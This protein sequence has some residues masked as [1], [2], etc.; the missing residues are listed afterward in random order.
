[1]L[2][3]VAVTLAVY[4]L[5]PYISS[6]YLQMLVLSGINV[7]LANSLNLISGITGQLSLGHAGF[8]AIGAYASAYYSLQFPGT[9]HFILSLLIGGTFAGLSGLLLGLP[10]LRLKGD[11]LAI[12]TLGFSEM[13]RVVFLNMEIVGGARGL[14]QIP[15]HTNIVWVAFIVSFTLLF[16]HRYMGSYA[17][18]AFLAIRENEMA[19]QTC[20]IHTTKYKVMSFS[21]GAFFA[22]TAGALFAHHLTYISPSI[23]TFTKSFEILTMV[24]LGGLGSLSGATISAVLL[25]FLPEVLRPLQ[26]ITHIDLRMVIYSLLLIILM[27]TRP[28]GMMGKKEIWQLFP[29]I[30]MKRKK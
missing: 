12:V 19:A 30:K 13:I 6:F 27:L 25:T 21:I 1:M 16:I 10:T 23:F 5:S 9:Y 18:R 2:A 14:P 15:H 22:G 7:V 24:V 17:G 26:Q 11:Y 20:G 3:V 4:F 8:M 29:L 28:G